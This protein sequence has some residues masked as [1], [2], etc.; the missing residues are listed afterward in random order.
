MERI[1]DIHAHPT[2][3]EFW[4]DTVGRFAPAL[5]KSEKI[6]KIFI[7][8]EDEVAEFYKSK[9]MVAVLVG[10]DAETNTGLPKLPNEYIA[11]LARKYPDTFLGFASVDPLKGE[12]ALHDLEYAIL[13]LGLKGV[14]FQ[15]GAQGFYPN[16]RRFYPLWE[17]CCE[18]RIPVQFHTG[19]TGLGEGL[20]GGG[21]IKLSHMKPIPYIDDVA[22][23]FP[24]LTIILLHPSWPWQDE[25]LAMAKHKGNVYLD[26]SGHL[27]SRFPESLKDA[28]GSYLKNKVLFGSD[29]PAIDPEMWV[30]EFKSLGYP[31]EVEDKVLFGNAKK[32]LQI[33]S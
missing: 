10:W 31:K 3:K 5:K 30:Q 2:C 23:D 15:Q 17:K 29:F 8:D 9:N 27:P 32:I 7:R 4:I 19:T 20:L 1:I 13:E 11:K 26:L 22:A 12:K 6:R 21:G 16:D 18:L 14:K 24:D 28:I 33:K 25:S